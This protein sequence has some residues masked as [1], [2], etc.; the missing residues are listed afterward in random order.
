MSWMRGEV[1]GNISLKF[2]LQL[3]NFTQCYRVKGQAVLFAVSELVQHL[4]VASILTKATR[5][6]HQI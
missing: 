3:P 2:L 4:Y 5:M 1:T 6:Q